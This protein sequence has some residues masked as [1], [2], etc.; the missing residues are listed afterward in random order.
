MVVV[1]SYT[2]G[3]DTS[4]STVQDMSHVS[5]T[6]LAEKLT[7]SQFPVRQILGLQILFS[8]SACCSVQVLKRCDFS[9]QLTDATRIRG[10]R[11]LRVACAVG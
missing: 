10:F 6:L 3:R 1:N 8:L 4:S 7:N 5:I 9:T 11:E 2:H